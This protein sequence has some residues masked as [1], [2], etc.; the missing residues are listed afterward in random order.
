MKK[1]DHGLKRTVPL[2]GFV[3]KIRSWDQ[4]VAATRETITLSSPKAESG[5]RRGGGR[6]LGILVIATRSTIT[7]TQ[8]ESGTKNFQVIT[9]TETTVTPKRKSSAKKEGNRRAAVTIAPALSRTHGSANR[10]TT[11]PKLRLLLATVI[12]VMRKADITRQAS[13]P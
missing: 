9:A 7:R 3:G 2:R 5:S 11:E 13:N 12:Q 6:I 1:S 4:P 8:S 10:K